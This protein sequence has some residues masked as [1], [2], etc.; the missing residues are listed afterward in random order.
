M[1][2][3]TFSGDR[4]QKVELAL[5]G[6]GLPVVLHFDPGKVLNFPPCFMGEHSDISCIIQNQS[7][8][9]PV[10]YRFQKTAHF[11]IDPGKGKIDE[12]CTQVR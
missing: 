12:G 9:L 11:K 1:A 5:T 7:K 8:C 6:S 10:M 2:V 3:I 4:L